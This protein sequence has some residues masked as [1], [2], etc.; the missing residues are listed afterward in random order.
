MSNTFID[1]LGYTTKFPSA[2]CAQTD[3]EVFFP[4]KGGSSKPAKRIC[5]K[6]PEIEPCLTEAL[7][8]KDSFGIRGGKSERERRR[9]IKEMQDA[10]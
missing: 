1:A 4:E 8:N 3:P 7:A 10:K 2:L 5:A 6:C 9:M